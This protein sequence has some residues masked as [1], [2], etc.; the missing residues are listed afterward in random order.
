[1]ARS[2]F[3]NK[4][5][6]DA[7]LGMPVQWTIYNPLAP[8]H[9]TKYVA[10]Y[11]PLA[12]DVWETLTVAAQPDV[13]RTVQVVLA[14]TTGSVTQWDVEIYGTD[15]WGN[16]VKA[17]ISEASTGTYETTQV[18]RTITSARSKVA[19]TLEGSNDEQIT[20]ESSNGL[21]LPVKVKRPYKDA[22]S[23][24]DILAIRRGDI[25]GAE[26]DPLT[27]ITRVASSPGAN[28]Y[29]LSFGNHSFVPGTAANGAEDFVIEIM[30]TWD[31][32]DSLQT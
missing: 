3:L 5:S 17:R 1:M 4:G 12:V 9:A 8:A 15:F 16:A 25:D 24:T 6:R 28:E 10:A 20:I 23:T 29:T 21:G 32:T 30:S 26:L 13:P 11:Q 2:A 19:G 14:D 31:M 22:D 7:G 27:T 18:F